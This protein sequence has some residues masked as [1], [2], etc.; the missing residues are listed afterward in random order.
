MNLCAKWQS[1]ML[2]MEL[3]S[4]SVSQKFQTENKDFP[5]R[6]LAPGFASHSEFCSRIAEPL[7]APP[8]CPEHYR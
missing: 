6:A 1:G 7:H 3:W 2:S 4:C 5:H 8:K